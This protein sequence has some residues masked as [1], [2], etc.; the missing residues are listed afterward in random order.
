MDTHKAKVALCI[1]VKPTDHEA[2]L[3][4]RCLG[5][6]VD[7]SQVQERNKNI[8]TKG[9]DGLAKHVDGVFITIAGSIKNE[10]CEAVA[11][12]YGAVVSFYEWDGSFANARNFN[13]SQVP[14]DYTH[15]VWSDTDDVWYKPE[16][17]REI[18][19][20]MVEQHFDV[21]RLVYKYDFDK[22][23]NC[24][25]VHTKTRIIRNDGC[26]SWIGAI[27]E[28]FQEHRHLFVVV[29][30]EDTYPIHLTDERRMADSQSRNLQ[31]AMAEA[32]AKPEDGHAYWNLANAYMACGRASEAGY[33]FTKF[34]ES[35][36]AAEEEKFLVWLRLGELYK[37]M[38]KLTHARAAALE[39]LALGPQYPDSYFLLGEIAYKAD[40]LINAE[41]FFE[42]GFTKETPEYKLIVWNPADYDYNPRIWYAKV[43][44]GLLKISKAVKEIKKCLKLRPKE[45]ELRNWMN[46]LLPELKKEEA[47]K[48]IYEQA[49]TIN[50]K[51]ELKLLLDSVPDEM[52]YYPP[53][54]H[55]RN[56]N[57][58]KDTSSG[59]D[60]VIYCSM[61]VHEWDPLVADTTGVGGSEEAVIQLAKRFKTSGYNVTVYA[62]TP[63]SQESEFDGI[64]W[65][66]FMAWNPRDKQDI[67]VLWRHPRFAEF[68]INSDQVYVDVHDVVQPEEFTEY[69]LSKITKVLFKSNVHREYYPNIPDDKCEI[70]PHG[71]DTQEFDLQ[72]EITPKN[73]YLVLNT[74]SPDRGL[75][76]SLAAVK[77]AYYKLPEDMRPLLK[78]S[79]YYGFDI[80]DADFKTDG[81][82][83]AWKADAIKQMDELKAMGVMTEDSGVRVSQKEVTR[84]YLSA[85][86]LLYPSEFFEIGFISGLKG[87]LA[88]CIPL[89]TDV[90]AQGEF[91]KGIKI[92]S[93]VTSS[94]WIKDLRS[95]KD[96]GIDKVDEVADKIVEYIMNINKY[97]DLRKEVVEHARNFTWDKTAALWVDVFNKND[98]R[99]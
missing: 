97:E 22:Y 6:I 13:F 95:G 18:A 72:R 1:I 38:G 93:D 69:R 86:L 61:T 65:K 33:M 49:K 67:T 89:T 81:E 64:T 77:A 88:G 70:I 85:G 75:K 5:G 74:S 62:N 14:K 29:N 76:T 8:N 59:K 68:D 34:I 17:I 7:K 20:Q 87:M 45:K 50:D 63:R 98:V 83:M 79:Q 41:H 23:G 35:P 55:L 36:L 10:K 16:N 53:I 90:F 15:I 43:L 11:A 21:A 37:S 47:A 26:V 40:N 54:A 46:E 92:H 73:P 30:L 48:K 56:T 42:M 78:F 52:K 91:C 99:R 44:M 51:N 27:H 66:P 80:W 96:Y 25:V 32:K 39:A 58:I 94:N 9:T 84:K 82:M 71:L 57:F 19:D 2:D 60:L 24:V 28:D 31:I 12:K 4:D 3:L